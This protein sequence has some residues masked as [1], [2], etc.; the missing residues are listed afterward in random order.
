MPTAIANTVTAFATVLC[1]LTTLA[2]CWLVAPQPWRWRLAY[3][4]IFVTGV[5]TVWYHGFGETFWQG[6]ADIGTNLLLAWSLQVAALWD[7]YAPRT[8]W[9]VAIL[10]GLINLLA[11]AGR[12]SMG[13]G[14][15]R[16]FP[17]RFGE[18][19]GFSVVELVLIADSLLAIGLLYGRHGHIP[20][21]ARPLLYIMT[22]LFLLGA[23]LA[24]ASNHR[25]D[26][27]ILAWHASWH[28]VGAFGFL[29]LWAFNHVR[30]N[31]ST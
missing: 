17:V 15:E 9:S 5:P 3:A 7:G 23:T 31:R 22:G 8:R 28:V 4:A 29:F 14:S 25:V 11:I 18:F 10:S 24:S 6:V 16:I 27:D 19:G 21:Q 30:F 1:G 12:V 13:S 2:F 26:F 20:T